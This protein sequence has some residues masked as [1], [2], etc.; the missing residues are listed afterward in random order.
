MLKILRYVRLSLTL[1]IVLMSSAAVLFI[2]IAIA[3]FIDNQ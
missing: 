1:L 3:V 2:L